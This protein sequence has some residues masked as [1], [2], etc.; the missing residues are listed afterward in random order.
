MERQKAPIRNVGKNKARWR[1][2]HF[3]LRGTTSLLR[4]ALH[5]HEIGPHASTS[6][7]NWH[8]GSDVQLQTL[9]VLVEGL[10]AGAGRTW[11]SARSG[12][13]PKVT[14]ENNLLLGEIGDQHVLVVS[15][16][17]DEVNIHYFCAI[18]DRVLFPHRFKCGVPRIHGKPI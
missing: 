17:R 16:P 12:R 8:D 4:Q 18:G 2:R 15:E 9:R 14:L 7:M 6:A 3:A 11:R 5:A 10:L 13:I 1:L